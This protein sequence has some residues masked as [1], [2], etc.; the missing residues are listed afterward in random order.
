M[1]QITIKDIARICG[2]GVSTVSRA[3]NDYNDINKETKEKILRVMKEY[4]YVPNNSARNLK[5]LESNTI[6]VLVKGV[7]NVFMT[8]M[9]VEGEKYMKKFKYSLYLQ[10]VDVEQD[11]VE[12]AI[13]LSKEKRLKGIVF[14][15]GYFDHVKER[16]DFLDIPFV[17]LTVSLNE[18]TSKFCSSVYV[19]DTK[20]SV[21]MVNYLCKL[22]HSRIALITTSQGDRSIGHLRRLGYLQG[23]KENGI[24]PS[25]ELIREMDNKTDEYSIKSGYEVTKK[26]LEDNVDFTAIYACSDYA[27]IGACKAL[28]EAGKRIPEDYSVAGY[29]GLE[30]ARYYNPQITTI[31]QPVTKMIHSAFD[32]LMEEIEGNA[33]HQRIVFDGELIVGESVKDISGKN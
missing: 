7:N 3:M 10:Q 26:L 28:F 18:G 30:I 19:D 1:S 9:L 29:D 12:V 6:A 14:L 20:E 21:R 27:A 13:Q 31:L 17:M 23:L 11:E 22:G 5:R 32:I 2:V 33:K 16:L 15:G 4:N 25:A 8:N 24:T